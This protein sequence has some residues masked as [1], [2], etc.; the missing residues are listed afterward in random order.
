[1]RKTLNFND[2][3]HPELLLTMRDE[4]Q[5]RIRVS[6]PTVNLQ[7]ELRANLGS[8]RAALNGEDTGARE[9][10]YEFAARL[11]NCNYDGIIVTPEDLAV[12]YLLDLEDL[13]VFYAAYLDFIDTIESEK[14]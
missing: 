13:V 2:F 1:M 12:K 10:L 11:I 8:I 4:K 5:T 9:A 6:A 7:E 3:V 14:N